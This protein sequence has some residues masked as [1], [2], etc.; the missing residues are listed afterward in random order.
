VRG[1]FDVANRPQCIDDDV[2]LDWRD[3]E[4]HAIGLDIELTLNIR[5]GRVFGWHDSLDHRAARCSP[6]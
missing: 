3:D 2:E 5:T 1:Q 4:V 6:G